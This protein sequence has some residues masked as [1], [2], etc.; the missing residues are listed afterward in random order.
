M[1]EI[2]DEIKNDNGWLGGNGDGWEDTPY[3]L[4]EIV[5]LVCHLNY[6]ELTSKVEKYINWS[7]DNQRPSGYFDPITKW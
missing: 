3:W 7:I 6:S 2:Y 1:D 5:Y 4:D